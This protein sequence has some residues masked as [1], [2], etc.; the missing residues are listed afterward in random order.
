MVRQDHGAEVANIYA[1]RMVVSPHRD[2][3]QAQYVAAPI[4]AL[5]D[6]NRL[7]RTLAWALEHLDQPLT[8]KDLARRCG[9]SARTFARRFPEA[10]GTTPLQWLLTQRIVAAQRMLETTDS[11]VEI[12][13]ERC[14][15][16][17]AATLRLHFG[18]VA[19]TSPSAYRSAFRAVSA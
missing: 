2:G 19:G 12:V 16:G 5:P 11:P 10:T 9:M 1:R 13:A 15:F 7:G 17:S 8:V 6:D 18:R 4:P 14:G 3:G